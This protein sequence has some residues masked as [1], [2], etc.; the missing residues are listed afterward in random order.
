MA[1][2][3]KDRVKETTTTSGTIPFVCTGAVNEFQTFAASIGDAN[4]TLYAAEDIGGINWEVGVGQYVLANNSLLRTTVLASSNN[5]SIVNFS[6]GPKNIFVTVPADYTALTSRDLTQFA[7][8]TSA[9]LFSIITD[10]T[11]SGQLVFANNAVL[12]NT[13]INSELVATGNLSVS[14]TLSG[15]STVNLVGSTTSTT[16]LGTA[17]STGTTNI[18]GTGQTGAITVGRSTATQTLNLGTGAT[19]SGSIKTINIGTAGVAGSNTNINIGG[20]AS[21]G[22]VYFNQPVETIDPLT[23]RRSPSQFLTI[24]NDDTTV[25][26]FIKSFSANNNAKPLYFDCSTV[27][28][29]PV[30]AGSLGY[31]FR[32]NGN[33][34]FNIDTSGTSIFTNTSSTGPA[35]KINQT[36]AGPA[37]LVEDETTPDST[38][39]VVDTNGNVGIGTNSPLGKLGIVGST[40]GA[41]VGDQ[42]IYTTLSSS[43]NGVNND[44]FQISNIRLSTGAG[45]TGSGTRLQQKVDSSWM[46]YMQFNGNT[47]NGGISFGTGQTTTSANSIPEVFRINSSGAVGIGTTSPTAKL[48]VAGSVKISQDL[49]VSGSLSIASNT[50]VANLN[51]DMLDGK[52]VGTSGS[53]IPTL[54]GNNIWAGEQRFQSLTTYMGDPSSNTYIEFS[55]ATNYPFIDFHSNTNVDFSGRIGCSGATAGSGGGTLDFQAAAYSFYSGSFT[56]GGSYGTI[57]LGNASQSQIVNIGTGAT[58]SGNTKSIGF[59]TSGVAGSTTNINIGSA[60][61][62]ALGKTIANQGMQLG[63]NGTPIYQTKLDFG[64]DTSGTWRKLFTVSLGTGQY[65]T[66]AYKID[67]VD[68]NANHAVV[69]SINADKYTYYVACIRTESTV[70]DYPDAC[71]ISGPASHIRAVRLSTG[72]YEIQVANEIQYQEY[73]ISIQLYA[74]N[75]GGTAATYYD[76]SAL[77]SVGANTYTAAVG[78]ATDWFQQ[79]RIA[80]S[81]AGDALRITQT[82]SGNALLVED[83]ANPDADPFVIK[84]DGNVISGAASQVAGAQYNPRLEVVGYDSSLSGIGQFQYSNNSGAAR[85]QFN[86]T[87]ATAPAGHVIVVEN[88]ELGTLTFAGSDGTGY[89]RGAQISAYVDGTP[90]TN[91]MPGRLVFSTTADGASSPTEAMRITNAQQIGIGTTSPTAKLDVVGSVKISQDLSVSGNVYISGN[92]TTLS[93]NNLV[94]NDS[95]IY[96]ANNNPA[97]LNDIGFVGN[98]TSGVYQHTGLVRDATDGVWKLFSNVVSEPTNTVDF[99]LAVY[100]SIRVGNVYGDLYGNA[101]TA[102]ALATGRTIELSGAATGTAT[103]FDGSQNITIPVT[104]L[105]SANL[106]GTIS[107]SLLNVGTTSSSGIVQLTDSVSSTSTTTAATPNSVKLSYDQATNAFVQAN[108]AVAIALASFSRANVE[109]IAQTAF[110]QANSAYAQANVA[111]GVGQAGFNRANVG[112]TQANVALAVGQAAY[113]KSNTAITVGSTPLY[114]GSTNTSIVGLISLRSNTVFVGNTAAANTF[115][116]PN[117]G[118]IVSDTLPNIPQSEPH[119]IGL[120]AEGV[121]HPTDANIYGIGVYGKGYTS[122]TTRSGGVVGEGHVQ[123]ATDV[124]AS[125]G[126]RGYSNDTH[127]GGHNIGLYGDATGASGSGSNYALYMSR[128]DIYSANA[129]SWIMNGNITYSGAYTVTIPTLV[130]TSNTLVANL[131]SDMLDGKHV[132][133][134]GSAIAALDGANIWGG[135]QRFTNNIVVTGSSG[136]SFVRITQTGTGNALTVEDETNP[137]SSP[138][139]V[140]ANGSVGIGT[141]SPSYKLHVVGSF[142]AN[143]KS[144]VID[145]PTKSGM[146]LRYGS[147]EGPENGVYVRGRTKTNII[148][149]PDYWVGLVD[150]TTITVNLTAIGAAQNLYVENIENNCVYISGNNINCFYTVYGERKDVDKLIVEF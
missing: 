84:A 102:T 83:S 144:F 140:D 47:N 115:R 119:N 40:V 117:T 125:V 19:S 69:G 145:H 21:G 121:A 16:S 32:I 78:T 106:T 123:T 95:I 91:D 105:N 93:S 17:A 37:L 42:T 22:N 80:S 6:A 4:T 68:P 64:S 74:E 103:S 31:I 87:R 15:T 134:S 73:L 75:G 96:L 13:T 55:R 24:Q 109:T 9:N 23:I 141:S 79:V 35:V 146:K 150:E 51:S 148:N 139:V 143:T 136:D 90:G 89:I 72:N 114:L 29:T 67:I 58:G 116:F 59:G 111:L 27:D 149:L 44:I 60:V 53:A 12:S 26:P 92:T 85:H 38:P 70:Q 81:G 2:I 101:N 135:T 97:N 71:Y 49:S 142:A 137:D 126:V 132:G 45:W 98:F 61:Q 3:I 10:E 34:V 124:G 18:G 86:K 5:N 57:T 100:D 48:D 33:N 129:Q 133:T 63:S 50:L 52:T 66:A 11:G 56:A 127:T 43:D 82:G 1:L 107:N 147:L 104:S 14:G 122:A 30:T 130:V 46:G 20:A 112:Y 94:I 110:T 118:V 99:S 77:A 8:T 138:F 41:N 36:G 28:L 62:G 113:N 76:G 88:D 25:S 108:T 39:F 128:G 120:V 54:D 131:N 7:P 65:Q